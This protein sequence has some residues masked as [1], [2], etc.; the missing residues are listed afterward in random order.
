MSLLT[1]A[2][3]S[4]SKFIFLN[5]LKNISYGS[6]FLFG[7]IDVYMSEIRYVFNFGQFS[8]LPL[9]KKKKKIDIFNQKFSFKFDIF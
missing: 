8:V 7:L 9:H 5:T 1:Y 6:E 4:V 3:T 2:N